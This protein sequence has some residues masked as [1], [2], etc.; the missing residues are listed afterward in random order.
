MYMALYIIVLD[1]FVIGQILIACEILGGNE[2]ISY[3]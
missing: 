1:M 3:I 2:Q